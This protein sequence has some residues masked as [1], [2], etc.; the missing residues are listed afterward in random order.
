MKPEIVAEASV[1]TIAVSEAATT[2]EAKIRAE[3]ETEGN[4]QV[5]FMGEGEKVKQAKDEVE[6]EHEI[7]YQI[8]PRYVTTVS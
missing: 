7:S 5:D 6:D 4:A 8:Q 1:M 3:A 2:G